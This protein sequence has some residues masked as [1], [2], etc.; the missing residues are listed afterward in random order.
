[1]LPSAS[2]RKGANEIEAFAVSGAGGGAQLA[3]AGGTGTQDTLLTRRRGRLVLV[4]ADGAATPLTSGSADG[5]IET[6]VATDDGLIV[7]G[8]ASDA[9]HRRPSDQVFL[10]ADGRLVQSA[11]PST[12]KPK[13]AERV[14]SG[15]ARAGFAFGATGEA[16][17]VV[18]TPERLRVVAMVNGR[19]T[20]I[21]PATPETFPAGQ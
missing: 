21:R 18:A 12:P 3:R 5:R 13:L 15:L 11:T 10:F 14:G 8:W 19:A 2:L 4:S 7:A 16:A 9:A 6:V 17:R 20:A 1:M